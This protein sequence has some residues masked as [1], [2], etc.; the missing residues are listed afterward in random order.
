MTR[1][2]KILFAA[3]LVAAPMTAFAQDPA[4]GTAGG[5]AGASVDVDVNAGAGVSTDGTGT[6]TVDADAS[7][8]MGVYTKENWPKAVGDRPLTRAK[9]MIEIEVDVF[10]NMSKDGVAK[11][12]A[13]APDI[14]YGV[15]DTL[16]VG[17]TH[18]LG[19]CLTG[20]DSGCGKVYNDV[21]FAGALS[22]MRDAKME[23]AVAGGLDLAVI[24]PLTLRLNIGAD[25]KYQAGKITIWS[26]PRIGIGLNKREGALMIPG[27]TETLSLPVVLG[28]QA[29]PELNVRLRTGIGGLGIGPEAGAPLDG[30][31]DGFVIPLG[32]GAL[33][34]VS[35]KLDVGAEFFFPGIAGSDLATAD[36]RALILTG[37]IRL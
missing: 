4:D 5:E 7:V 34:A 19:L 26:Y 21:G 31:G 36:N 35:N 37:N 11:P 13:I 23:L 16:T 24:D 32:I 20:T 14:W 10:V 25:F 9:G 15:S 3:T 33:Y 18:N 1:L 28:F 12:I 30:F 2:S 6:A 17:L 22:V 27:N 8:G 29:T